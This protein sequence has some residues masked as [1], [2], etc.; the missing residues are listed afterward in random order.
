MVL[1]DLY[2]KRFDLTVCYLKLSYLLFGTNYVAV[3]TQ[4]WSWKH[5]SFHHQWIGRHN[6]KLQ[7]KYISVEVK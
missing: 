6:K 5:S 7:I 2:L 3:I 1:C 4:Y